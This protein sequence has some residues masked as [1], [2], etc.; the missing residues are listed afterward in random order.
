[1]VPNIDGK[2]SDRDLKSNG[3]DSRSYECASHGFMNQ[4][5]DAQGN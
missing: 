2:P 4:N 3:N 5:D 1:M